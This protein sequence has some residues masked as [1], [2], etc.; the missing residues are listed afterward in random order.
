M[1]FVK[2]P[3]STSKSTSS[4]GI[5]VPTIQ[6]INLFFVRQSSRTPSLYDHVD[7]VLSVP[8]LLEDRFELGFSPVKMALKPSPIVTMMMAMRYWIIE[9]IQRAG[10]HIAPRG[11]CTSPAPR[12]KREAVDS[13]DDMVLVCCSLGRE[14]LSKYVVSSVVWN[15]N[16]FFRVNGRISCKC[17]NRPA[18]QPNMFYFPMSSRGDRSA[19]LRGGRMHQEWLCLHRRLTIPSPSRPFRGP[20]R[21]C[22]PMLHDRQR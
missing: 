22:I 17:Q 1:P 16:I 21:L 3:D 9:M 8:G 19:F 18:N 7:F 12:M 13:W 15:V 2:Q 14:I 4:I 6:A 5:A 11:S 10:A 20:V